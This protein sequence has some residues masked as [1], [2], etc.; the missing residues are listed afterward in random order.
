M[1]ENDE[2]SDEEWYEEEVRR[3]WTTFRVK[4]LAAQNI[5]LGFGIAMI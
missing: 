1:P 4:F 2:D 5:I 3:D